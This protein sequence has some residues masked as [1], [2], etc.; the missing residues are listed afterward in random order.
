[1]Y[2]KKIKLS[3]LA[4]G[5]VCVNKRLTYIT[6]ETLTSRH[7]CI[8]DL[9]AFNLNLPR[10]LANC[11]ANIRFCDENPPMDTFPPGVLFCTGCGAG[12]DLF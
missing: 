7:E 10:R 12:D 2:V 5:V 3:S 11:E 8:F 6:N 4:Y 9:G 1:M